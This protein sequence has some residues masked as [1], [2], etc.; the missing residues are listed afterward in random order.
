MDSPYGSGNPDEAMYSSDEQEAA[1]RG[2]SLKDALKAA[3]T[4]SKSDTRTPKMFTT[5]RKW[6]SDA[7]TARKDLKNL[8]IKLRPLEDTFDDKV[9]AFENK[10]RAKFEQKNKLLI[11]SFDAARKQL[12]KCRLHERN[13]KL[14][15]AKKHGFGSSLQP[16]LQRL[17]LPIDN[18][19]DSHDAPEWTEQEVRAMMYD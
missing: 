18:T 12:T 4:A 16:S 14:R 9:V 17:R 1:P 15:I 13:A 8:R 19:D 6:K 2:P 10:E 11:D 5:Y 3:R 7:R